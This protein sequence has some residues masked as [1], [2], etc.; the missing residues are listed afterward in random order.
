MYIEHIYTVK[1]DEPL[2]SNEDGFYHFIQACHE[3]NIDNKKI[4][5]LGSV[6][7]SEVKIFN[8]NAA[9]QRCI[10]LKFSLS[11]VNDEDKFKKLLKLI[12]GMMCKVAEFPPEIV[13]DDMASNLCA[14]AYPKI[15]YSENLL[16]KLIT[17]F[18]VFNIGFGWH[19]KSVPDEVHGTIKSNDKSNKNN[20]LYQLDFIQLSSLLFK[21]YTKVNIEDKILEI[22]K[23]LDGKNEI[24]LD[25]IEKIKGV[26]PES[27]WQRYFKPI[28]LCD[29]NYLIKRWED[30][31]GL[32]CKVAHNRFITEDE[33][34]SI[35][36]ITKE[37]N[38]KFENALENISKII[39]GEDERNSVAENIISS[40]EP[41]FEA[42]LDICRKL[43]NSLQKVI[44]LKH[45]NQE[46]SEYDD[47]ESA[48]TTLV[49]NKYIT[50]EDE[51][52]IIRVYDI[53][54]NI[55]SNIDFSLNSKDL[56]DEISIVQDLIEKLDEL[57]DSLAV[58]MSRMRE[59]L[60]EKSLS[61]DENA[62]PPK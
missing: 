26:L 47:V 42:F 7:N 29:D 9:K 41:S 27:N 15:H 54:K 40:Y 36:R 31:Y 48:L 33:F 53:R 24:S 32:R 22:T 43:E 37:V 44:D 2:L 5:F 3:I 16:R 34:Q 62:P 28:I 18:M 45:F 23:S 19:K 59:D 39:V 17:T 12:K 21:K 20:Y 58:G 52:I 25:D 11:N 57:Y 14:K 56:H 55:L 13:W 60:W 8:V 61:T 4:L 10:H 38:E 49:N 1:S 30:L 6:F 51:L 46:N 35:D 50:E